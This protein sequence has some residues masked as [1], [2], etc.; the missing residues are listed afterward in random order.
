MILLP[1]DISRVAI[2]E[3]SASLTPQNGINSPIRVSSIRN[4]GTHLAAAVAAAGAVAAHRRGASLAAAAAAATAVSVTVAPAMAIA[5]AAAAAATYNSLPSRLNSVT[6]RDHACL[7][8]GRRGWE[9]ME[10][11]RPAK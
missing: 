7:G 5:A 10:V 8:A 6:R 1:G 4:R 2:S 3:S 11:L 9:V